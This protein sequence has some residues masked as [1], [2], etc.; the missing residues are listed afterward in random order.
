[1]TIRFFKVGGCIR[2]EL[3]GQKSKDIDFAVE[4]PSFEAMRNEIL[5]RGGKIFLETPEHFT[6]RANIPELGSTDYVLCRREGP[7]S[8]GRHPDWVEVGTIF[9]DLARRDFTM[10][11]IAR[12][13]RTG[14][15][16]DPH[17]GA[18]DIKNR[19]IRCVGNPEERFREDKLRVF[20]ALR[21]MVTKGFRLHFDTERAAFSVCC[22]D[23]NFESVSTERI[24]EELSKMFE[25]DWLEAL[26]GLEHFELLGL[27]KA[28]GI[29]LKPTIEKV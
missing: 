3:L 20:R 7:Y 18:T 9:D 16:L 25:V 26:D 10:N 19:I 17:N 23:R 14:E 22:N 6:I 21:F 2:D 13:V 28:R 24:R 11:A 5:N 12:D 29:W 4:A 8:D 27:V 1:M 15:L